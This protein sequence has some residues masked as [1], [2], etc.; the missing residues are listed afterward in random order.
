VTNKINQDLPSLAPDQDQVDAFKNIRNS[1]IAEGAKKTQ[2]G[3]DSD[4]VTTKSHGN[5]WNTFFTVL[6]F[7]SACLAGW[8]FYQQDMR[9]QVLLASS[10]QRIKDLE[11]QLS[12]T[13][14]EMGESAGTISARLEKQSKKTDELWVQMDKLWASAWR[15]NQADI[16]AANKLIKQNTKKLSSQIKENST[17]TGSLKKNAQKQSELEF[18]IAMLTEQVEAAVTTQEQLTQFKNSI[19]SMQTKSLGHDQ[20]QIDLAGSISQMNT[21]QKKLL[22]RIKQLESKLGTNPAGN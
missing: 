17:L 10:E 14:K 20:Q 3:A 9:A 1:V 12:I 19:A 6:I 5:G 11:E 13:G 16:I 2:S 22:D 21:T 4:A 7:C 15:R 18:T 8:W